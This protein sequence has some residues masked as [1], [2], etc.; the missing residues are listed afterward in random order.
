MSL[1]A[2]LDASG[3]R[4]QC[5]DCGTVLARVWFDGVRERHLLFPASMRPGR[6]GV[7]AETRRARHLRRSGRPGNEPYRE[8]VP[9]I[10][11][12]WPSGDSIAAVAHEPTDY[13][14]RVECTR[15]HRV[16]AVKA[17]EM[18]VIVPEPAK[19]ETGPFRTW[20][21]AEPFESIG[22]PDA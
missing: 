15:C 2:R 4:V 9:A 22:E 21:L 17:A 14:L 5:R 7:W 8:R 12:I 10:E 19:E 18:D 13:P 1:Q 20:N 11:A 6:A 16:Q 3:R